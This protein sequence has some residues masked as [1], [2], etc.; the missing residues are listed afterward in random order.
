MALT[1]F[2]LA[3]YQPHSP[4]PY[5]QR[6]A[7]IL[8][9]RPRGHRNLIIAPGTPQKSLRLLPTLFPAEA[10]AAEAFWPAKSKQVFPAGRLGRK[11]CLQLQQVPRIIFHGQ[12]HHRLWSRESNKYPP[13][14]IPAEP[15]AGSADEPCHASVGTLCGLVF[16]TALFGIGHEAQDKL[17]LYE[18]LYETFGV[19]KIRLPSAEPAIRQGLAPDAVSPTSA[20]Q[21]AK[22]APVLPIQAPSIARSIPSPLPRPAAR[23]VIQT[24][25][26]TVQACCCTSVVQIDTRP[27]RR[28]LQLRPA[29]S[30]RHLSPTSYMAYASSWREWEDRAG[31]ALAWVSGYHR[32]T[33]ERKRQLFASITHAPDQ[34]Y[35]PP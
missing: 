9:Y 12:K 29:S 15:P 31:L 35:I 23:R 32:S 28:Q 24:A 4:E 10:R 26:V 14:L 2:L 19:L 11:A 16:A 7:P 5:H 18:S 1:P 30:C 8:K 22:I 25:R 6:Q 33:R 3:G 27:L 34:T 13:G 17:P 20:Q 21:A